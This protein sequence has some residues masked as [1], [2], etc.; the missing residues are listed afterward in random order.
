MSKYSNERYAVMIHMYCSFFYLLWKILLFAVVKFHINEET[1][2]DQH[3][4]RILG[5]CSF[6]CSIVLGWLRND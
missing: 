1:D 6:S 3:W 2:V 4:H 5:Q